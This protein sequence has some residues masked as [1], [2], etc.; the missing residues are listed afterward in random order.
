MTHHSGTTLVEL[1]VSLAI[2]ALLAG[3]TSLAV[4]SL[5]RKEDP[6]TGAILDRTKAEAIRAGRPIRVT[7]DTAGAAEPSA[8]LVLPDGRIVGQP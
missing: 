4:T 3:V 1:I 6:S 2:L 5:Q 7:V 8:L